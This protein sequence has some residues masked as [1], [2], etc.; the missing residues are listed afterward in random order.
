MNIPA[1]I[2]RKVSEKFLKYSILKLDR[3]HK[4]FTKC[5][6]KF[7]I[8]FI[9]I[10]HAS[11]L[12]TR[13]VTETFVKSFSKYS[14]LGQKIFKPIFVQHCRNIFRKITRNVA[15][16]F[17]LS[18]HGRFLKLFR[19]I[20]CID[21]TEDTNVSWNVLTSLRQHLLKYYSP[22]PCWGDAEVF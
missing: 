5:C 14:Y 4:N 10:F 2:T 22:A 18:L 12:H 8:T 9:E 15:Q 3:G 16:I 13:N 1:I 19:N 17:P 6:R 7:P 20:S 11:S 21:W